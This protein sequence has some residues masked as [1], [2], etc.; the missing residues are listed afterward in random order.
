MSANSP[1]SEPGV[2]DRFT[3]IAD[4]PEFTT[5]VEASTLL[6]VKKA[7]LYGLVSKGVLPSVRVGRQIRIPRAAL[8]ALA[9]SKS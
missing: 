2:V 3:R 6:A 8:E 1:S 5:V 9:E 4:L 7:T